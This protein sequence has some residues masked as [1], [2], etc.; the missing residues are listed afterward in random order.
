[1]NY[2]KARQFAETYNIALNTVYAMCAEGRLPHVRLGTGR[3]TIRI[4]ADALDHLVP[5]DVTASVMPVVSAAPPNPVVPRPKYVKG[6][7]ATVGSLTNARR[8][9]S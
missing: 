2:L 1:M 4:P 8:T 7:K 3:G 9:R 6:R 5:A